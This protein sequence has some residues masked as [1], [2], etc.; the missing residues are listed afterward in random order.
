MATCLVLAMGVA[1]GCDRTRKIRT[2]CLDC[3]ATA[4]SD[5]LVVAP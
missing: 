5:V 3:Q 4:Y 2:Q 1:L